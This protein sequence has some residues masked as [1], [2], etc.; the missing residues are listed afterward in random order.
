MFTSPF[1]RSKGLVNQEVLRL[2]DEGTIKVEYGLSIH[3][4]YDLFETDRLQ[5]L[6]TA[7]AV[8]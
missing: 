7:M 1:W 3:K 4:Y 2:S 5:I 8:R 6:P